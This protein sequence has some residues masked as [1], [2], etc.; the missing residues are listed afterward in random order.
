MDV[1]LRAFQDRDFEFV[2]EIYFETM[3]WAIERYLGWNRLQQLCQSQASE[4][5]RWGSVFHRT[6]AWSWPRSRRSACFP[7]EAYPPLRSLVSVSGTS[8]FV[9][10]AEKKGLDYRSTFRHAAHQAS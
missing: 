6:P 8:D 9:Q 7:A 4:F 5:A 10:R 2:R 3:R 1:R